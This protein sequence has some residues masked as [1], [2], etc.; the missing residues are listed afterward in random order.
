MPP[1]IWPKKKKYFEY[2]TLRKI[3]GKIHLEIILYFLLPHLS[4][5]NHVKLLKFKIV[6]ISYKC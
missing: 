5:Q 2:L 4:P 1:N 6:E 3:I